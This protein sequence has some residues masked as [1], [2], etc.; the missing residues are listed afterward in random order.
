M[1][2]RRDTA[3][4]LAASPFPVLQ[5]CSPGTR[6]LASAPLSDVVSLT[7]LRDTTF[8]AGDT[9]ARVDVRSDG[10]RGLLGVATDGTAL[11]AAWTPPDGVLVVGRLVPGPTEIVWRGPPSSELANG[12]HL[13]ER[14]GTLYVGIGD[15]EDPAR[16][17]D[18]DAPNGKILALDPAG[19]PEQS[20][21]VV[22]GGWNNP[23][24]FTFDTEGRLVV[25]SHH[26]HILLVCRM[27]LR[28]S[29]DCPPRLIPGRCSTRF[30]IT[31]TTWGSSCTRHRRSPSS[32]C[33]TAAT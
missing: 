4:V 16:V 7:R 31:W 11:W 23:F 10:Q 29:Q 15:L 27:I 33:S 3:L 5:A 32:P 14:D 2:S 25:T 1:R 8:E 21:R 28:C 17:G 22:S 30:S 18:P 26:A 13:L 6:A 20:P 24:A 9:L 19:P 12:G